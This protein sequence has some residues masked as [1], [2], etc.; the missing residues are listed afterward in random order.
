M[1]PGVKTFEWGGKRKKKKKRKKKQRWNS[2]RQEQ[3]GGPSD[4]VRALDVLFFFFLSLEPHP[5]YMEV[6]R[7]WVESELQVPAYTTA[8]AA[9]DLSHI[10]NLCHS[11]RQ[12]RILNSL[13]EAG[14]PARILM[15]PSPIL[16]PLSHNGN[17][18]MSF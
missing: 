7:L 11:L 15:V 5:Q 10:C 1:T 6:P 18:W 9:P 8:T 3:G 17:S 4:G 2:Y 13:S 14:D 16:N 12:C